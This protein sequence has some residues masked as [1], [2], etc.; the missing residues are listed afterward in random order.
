MQ[1][2]RAFRPSV[3]P[4]SSARPVEKNRSR[5]TWSILLSKLSSALFY[6][7]FGVMG[8]DSVL[9]CAMTYRLAVGRTGS[10]RFAERWKKRLG[11]RFYQECARAKNKNGNSFM[12]SFEDGDLGREALRIEQSTPYA[13][14]R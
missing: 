12:S 14:A 10:F 1:E 9:D 11:S 3:A 5:H 2:V 8:T 6:T 7:L 4:L 13:V